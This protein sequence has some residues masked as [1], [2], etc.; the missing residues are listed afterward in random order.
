MDK[1]EKSRVIWREVAAYVYF[2]ICLFDFVI[3]PMYTTKVNNDFREVLVRELSTEERQYMI[4][5]LDRLTLDEWKSITLSGSGT[6]V[7]HIS[8]VTLLTG[9]TILDRKWTITP[10]GK[11]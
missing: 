3:M 5:I 2:I 4:N 6:I 1:K 7:F 11:K 8:F 10:S 9:S